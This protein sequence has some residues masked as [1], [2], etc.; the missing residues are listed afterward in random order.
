MRIIFIAVLV[1]ATDCVEP[2]DE[3]IKKRGQFPFERI[4]NRGLF[5]IF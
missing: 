3:T 5:L 2:S 4:L 1:L